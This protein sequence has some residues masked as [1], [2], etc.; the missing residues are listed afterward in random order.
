MELEINFKPMTPGQKTVQVS[1]PK[2]TG[3]DGKTKTTEKDVVQE[4]MRTVQG[5]LAK[6]LKR[7]VN[8]RR[9]SNYKELD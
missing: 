2:L 1:L 9:G 5:R 3:K 7:A 4:D 6:S 8:R